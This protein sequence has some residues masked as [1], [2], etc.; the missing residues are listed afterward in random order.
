MAGHLGTRRLSLG[1]LVSGFTFHGRFRGLWTLWHFSE[2]RTR[3]LLRGVALWHLT[4]SPRTLCPRVHP[5]RG[6]LSS[7]GLGIWERQVHRV[8]RIFQTLTPAVIMPC[9]P[10]SPPVSSGGAL[11]AEL[12]GAWWWVQVSPSS[13][14]ASKLP[15]S[16]G[17]QVLIVAFSL[18]L[19]SF[20][21]KDISAGYS[22]QNN[23]R[24]AGEPSGKR[25]GCCR[26]RAPA[27]SQP[28]RP[29]LPGDRCA[30]RVPSR[31]RRG[32]D[33]MK[34]FGVNPACPARSWLQGTLTS[35]AGWGYTPLAQ[36]RAPVSAVTFA[37]ACH[38]S[39]LSRGVT[40]SWHYFFPLLQLHVRH[41]EV[42]RLGVKW[43]L[44][45]PACTTATATRDLSHVCDL[46][47]S[48]GN[49]GSLTH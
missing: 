27:P 15:L 17:Q 44:Q 26:A 6:R 38:P 3:W 40:S 24:L 33:L 43:E 42:P 49:T 19:P 46:C 39:R 1:F 36:A 8:V 20:V 29:A 30:L 7:S 11:I 5:R 9:S 47:H 2:L 10:A 4:R 13:S 48:C 41:M 28:S 37:Q 34:P 23:P 35:R 16:H 21:F 18:T 14:F 32:W 25:D 12:P 22:P 31:M 45:P